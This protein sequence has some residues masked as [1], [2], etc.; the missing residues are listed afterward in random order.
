M[1]R[2]SA[3][4][5]GAMTGSVVVRVNGV[6]G[7]GPVFTVTNPPAVSSVSTTRAKPGDSVTIT[8]TGFGNDQGIGQVWL[9][10]TYGVVTGWSDTQIEAT[11]ALNSRTGTV[12]V[13]QSGVWSNAV[14]FTVDTLTITSVYPT[15]GAVG[16]VITIT[17][18]GFG[19]TQ[20]TG[21]V[22]L[23]SL[24]GIVQDPGW[25]H[26]TIVAKVASGSVTGVAR[27]QQGGVWSNAVTFTVTGPG[28]MTMAPSVLNLVVGDTRTL[29]ALD[30]TSHAVTG[31]NWV[32]SD[33]TVVSLSGDDPPVLTAVAAGH[34]TVTAGAASADVTVWDPSV[35]P[36]GTLPVGTVLWS[37]PGDGSGVSSIVPAVPSASGVADVFA[38]QADGTVA[39]IT[40][41]GLTAWT[42]DVSGAYKVIPDFQAGWW[43]VTVRG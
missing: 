39:A 10:S 9:G 31:L 34:V 33:P 13:L 16:D 3:G 35:L 28:A 32:S 27:V 23:G 25:S 43:S 4:T 7:T 5:G 42:A 2:T 24:P 30:G 21:T 41:D 37:N 19:D 15:S 8:G 36:G 29:Q 6:S 20:G 18:S 1:P 14:D 38:F 11:V 17:G 12:K 22:I 40:A 26:D